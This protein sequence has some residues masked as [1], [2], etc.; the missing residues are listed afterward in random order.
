MIL[1]QG[2][3]FSFGAALE[4]RLTQRYSYFLRNLMNEPV[5]NIADNSKDM[6]YMHFELYAYLMHCKHNPE[7]T[8]KPSIVIWQLT[9]TFRYGFPD[10]R[11]SGSWKPNDLKSIIHPYG[12]SARFCK[13][14][15]WSQFTKI[16]REYKRLIDDGYVEDAEAYRA[17]KGMGSILKAERQ[18]FPIGDDTFQLNQLQT[19]TYINSIQKLCKEMD[20]KLVIINYYGTPSAMLEDPI[21]KEIDRSDF[22]IENSEKWGLYNHL[23]WRGFDRSVDDFHFNVDAHYYQAEK[24]YDFIVHGKRL[25]VEEEVHDNMG[26][27]PVFDYVDYASGHQAG[28]KH[29]LHLTHNN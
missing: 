10:F 3:S 25:R 24:L 9:D 14:L 22:L 27:M 21:Y 20:I 4:S 18:E 17:N 11:Y 12:Y 13:T 7:T 29:I 23:C 5:K 8:E 2:C 15:L 16:Q 1:V 19:G 6:K 28:R 26:H